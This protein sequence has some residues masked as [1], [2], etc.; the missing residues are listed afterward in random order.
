MNVHFRSFP[1]RHVPAS[2]KARLKSSQAVC[3]RLF[4]LATRDIKKGE[5]LSVDYGTNYCRRHYYSRCRCVDCASEKH[6]HGKVDVDGNP[7]ECLECAEQFRIIRA[8][9]CPYGK[10][11]YFPDAKQGPAGTSK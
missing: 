8:G 11:G 10:A 1:D 2:R 3:T 4:L 9:G 6:T 5:L 7:V